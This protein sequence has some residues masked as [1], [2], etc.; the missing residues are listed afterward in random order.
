M[1]ACASISNY[2]NL[3]L[4]VVLLLG[5]MCSGAQLLLLVEGFVAPRNLLKSSTTNH[6]DVKT[7]STT[8]TLYS[9]PTVL[10]TFTS[11]LVSICRLPNGVTVSKSS[12]S[13]DSEMPKLL[14]LYDVENSRPCRTVREM[15]T[16]L[17]LNV[18]KVI[19]SAPNSRA[20]QDPNYDYAIPNG[21]EV[22]TLIVSD[23]TSDDGDGEKVLSGE[24][25][26]VQYLN[27]NFDTTPTTT[28]TDNGQQ[29]I[30]EIIQTA[31][32]Y[33]AGVLRPGRGV[34]VSPAAK[35]DVINKEAP[36]IL[37]SYEG[38]QFCRLVRE[39]L[40]EL[41]V[42]YELRNVGKESP[43]R[44]ELASI[45]GG[46]TQCPYIVDPSTGTSM[47]ESADIIRYLYKT[48]GRWTPPNELLQWAS[49]TIIPLVSPLF[50]SLAPIQ[51]GSNREDTASYQQELEAAKSNIEDETKANAVVVYTYKLSPFCTEATSLLDNLGIEYK[52]ISLGL[53]WIPGLITPEGSLKRAALLDMT[54]QSSLPHV[55]VG[56]K[57]IG[58]LFSGEPGLVPALDQGKL[59]GWVNE[60]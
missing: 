24:E 39:T 22:P 20:I 45:T 19:P 8:T 54:G 50:S 10:D 34:M 48:Y 60:A 3:L 52:E 12:S 42:V 2:N 51:A 14:K 41:D 31:G 1:R 18:E 25:A 9:V 36:L 37:Y 40:T 27:S 30:M 53:E 5:Y 32:S 13:R 15:I 26:I 28:I 33:I 11:G 59:L 23:S 46:S 43:R 21:C 44:S 49:D 38:N 56:G 57:S 6:H 17:D 47:A 16:E 4:L 55:F 29:D 58:G 35:K 7:M